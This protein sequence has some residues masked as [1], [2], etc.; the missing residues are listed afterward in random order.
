MRNK[1]ILLLA[2]LLAYAFGA[3]AQETRLPDAPLSLQQCVAY[4]LEHSPQLLSLE[5][6]VESLELSYRMA[7]EAFL[8]SLNASVGENISFGRSQGKDFV[9]RDIS[10]ANTSF[11]VGAELQIFSGGSRWYQLKKSGAARVTGEY[12]IHEVRD[13]I[14]LQ[15]AS[16]YIQFLLS[17]QML[18]TARENLA[19]TE[20]LYGQVKEQ[21]RLGKVALSKQIEVESQLGRDQLAVVET[22]ADLQRA[23]KALLLDMGIVE[24]VEV[25]FRSITPE[26]VMQKLQSRP[27]VAGNGTWVLPRTALL[28][29]KLELAQYDLKIAKSRYLPTL[30]LNAGY[31]N[32]YY[33]NF[34]NGVTIPNVAF[35]DQ[36]KQNGRSYIGLSLSIPIY[37]RG[38]VRAGVKQAE[39]DR[40]NKQAQLIQQQYTDDR[41]I[42]LA[43]AD[44]RKAEEQYRVSKENVALSTKSLEMA[45]LEYKAGRISTY[46]WEQAK[47]RKLQATAS[48]LQSVYN[49]LLR[50]INLKY[51][52]SGELDLSF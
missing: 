48:Y 37:N 17:D 34:G 12:I 27:I 45:D 18:Q 33:H 6:Q 24:E 1:S 2:C 3:K 19:L 38:Q 52:Q 28:Q 9:Y 26:E 10:S 40:L 13:Q 39:L 25:A 29:K 15:V 47:N 22:E 46:E 4:A 50:T 49:Q 21:V 7:K 20:Q 36:L 11:G 5:P 43:K 30:S 16:S 35:A 32:G 14:A 51:L 44:L 41:N 8:P 31:S 42:T 23:K